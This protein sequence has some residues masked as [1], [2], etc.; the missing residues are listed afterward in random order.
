M[1]DLNMVLTLN[2]ASE[3]WGVP[4]GTL[5]SKL[6]RQSE[7]L[8]EECRKSGDVWLVT[9][10]A[11]LRI[12]GRQKVARYEVQSKMV[13]D[14]KMR[15][16][17]DRSYLY[18]RLFKTYETLIYYLGEDIMRMTASK[19][20]E[21]TKKPATYTMRIEKDLHS[22]IALQK[23]AKFKKEKPEIAKYLLDLAAEIKSEIGN[24]YGT[25]D[26]S[27]SVGFPFGCDR[28]ALEFSKNDIGELADYYRDHDE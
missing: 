20:I 7:F 6:I 27:L 2:E 22:S 5:R 12:Y 11:M 10:E 13:I 26:T 17:K 23:L 15:E 21:F 16:D 14:K 8:P 3:L 24:I 25:L 18:G 28:Q 1:I 19:M 9:K 4:T